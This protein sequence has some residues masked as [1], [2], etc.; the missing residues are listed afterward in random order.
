MAK[1]GIEVHFNDK[2]LTKLMDTLKELG[3]LR[4]TVGVQGRNATETYPDDGPT[5]S[6]V[7]RFNEFGTR[8]IPA[9]GFMRRAV[10]EEGRTELPTAAAMGLGAVISKGKDPV[11]GLN[12]IGNVM[13]QAVVDQI[14]SADAWAAPNAPATIKKKGHAQPLYETGKL[15]EAITWAVKK[16]YEI[17]SEG[18]P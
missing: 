9:R 4:V 11:Q 10:K 7:A 16:G 2:G 18:K 13:A 15:R 17:K 8:D 3:K 12:V 1:A 14:K 5:I 6:A